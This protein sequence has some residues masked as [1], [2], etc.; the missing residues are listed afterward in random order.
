M[1]WKVLFT[2]STVGF[3]A[4][5]PASAETQE[6]TAA[7]TTG[8]AAVAGPAEV[9]QSTAP[10]QS[11]LVH[12][13]PQF[14]GPDTIADLVDMAAPAVVN[15]VC[16]SHITRDQVTRL[17]LDQ[18]GREDGVRKLRKHFGLD[19][20]SDEIGNT[21]K[22]TGAGVLVRSDGFILTSLHVVKNAEEIKVT[23]K[24]KRSY[25][26]KVIGRDSYTDLAVIKIEALGLPTVKFADAD[27]LRLGQWVVAIGNPYAYENSV[28]AGLVSGLHREAKN[29][30]EAFG[31]RSGALTFIQTDVP[32]NPG[33]S[34]GPLLNMQGEVIGINSFV[35]DEAQNI[36]FAIPSN[37]AK[38]I[39]DELM[40]KGAAQLGV[41]MRDPSEMPEGAGVISGVEITKVKV[42]S[43]ASNGG[44]QVGDLIV[45][46]DSTIV[47]TPKDV[48]QV[49]ANH[50][51]GDRINVHIKRAGADKNINIKVENLPEEL[52]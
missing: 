30:S 38:R 36:G 18:R 35:R 29:F 32:L 52:D 43:P 19:V 51:I 9:P 20:P 40:A 4:I 5:N 23:L 46:M 15:I 33:S 21:I 39:G 34:G 42:P 24:D 31:A 17:K 10:A 2:L 11:P 26:A 6:V 41:E 28:S 13:L 49:I 22:T 16:S 8:A 14:M 47:H 48:S 3:M 45:E 44:M 27:K 7:A 12:Q 1:L 25:D 50:S 37:T